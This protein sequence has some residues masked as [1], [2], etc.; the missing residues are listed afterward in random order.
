M[1]QYGALRFTRFVHMLV[2]WVSGWTSSHPD[3]EGSE[4]L[5][6]TQTKTPKKIKQGRE[7]NSSK[8]KNHWLVRDAFVVVG[9]KSLPLCAS[10][11]HEVLLQAHLL[12]HVLAA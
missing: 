12:A 10:E 2:L 3:V 8:A 5:E 11:A 4:T 6:M 1:E 7:T 9:P